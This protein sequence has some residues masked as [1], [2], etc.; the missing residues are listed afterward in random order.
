MNINKKDFTM[1]PTN[2]NI[3][4]SKFKRQHNNKLTYNTGHLVPIYV[5][6][7]LPGDTV[8]M[9]MSEIARMQ[10]PIFPVMDNGYIDTYFF[11]VPNRLVWEH[12]EE[13]MGEN[14]TGIWEQ[15]TE[16][17][18]P[19]IKFNTDMT[20]Y[21]NTYD[22]PFLKGA[23]KYYKTS[24]MCSSLADYMGIPI[25]DADKD[26]GP[27][28][29]YEVNALPFRAYYQIF[30]DWFRD[31][32]LMYPIEFDRGDAT[33]V[34]NIEGDLEECLPLWSPKYVAKFHDY[35]TS[36]LPQPQKSDDV[37]LPL[38][39]DAPIVGNGKGITFTDGT[40]TIYN[41]NSQVDLGGN[42]ML[43]GLTMTK[44]GDKVGDIGTANWDNTGAIDKQVLG[45]GE[46]TGLKVDL[47]GATAS[48]IN[49]L[50]QAFAV[51]KFYEQQA[52][53][54]SRYTEIIKS[55]F[56]VT[57]PD[58]RLQRA[59]YLGGARQAININQVVQQSA[60]DNG[61]TITQRGSSNADPIVYDMSK[62]STPQ[63]NVSAYSLTT[64]NNNIFTKS[65]TE[66]GILMGLQ[67]IRTEHSYQNGLNKLWSKRNK[68]D[69]Y[70][71]VFANIGE[72]AILNKEIYLNGAPEEGETDIDNEAFGY[73]EAWAEYRYHPNQ[74]S[75]EFRSN[76]QQT[77]D[78]WHW[79]DNYGAQVYLSS[80]WLEEN[81]AQVNRTIAVTDRKAD[82][83]MADIWFDATYTRPMPVYS[84]PGLIDHH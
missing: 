61:G 57:S 77:L 63:G 9:K 37:M 45:F 33:V 30:N 68:F 18:I 79:G 54:G 76:Y 74:I 6:E 44:M 82:Q 84:I 29:E 65:F 51:Q 72:Q 43:M 34:A 5:S 21:D 55:M 60:T 78:S 36:A 70:F 52:R 4:R 19:T 75:G 2:L 27:A 3:N 10:T 25:N 17:E 73:Q 26:K 22:I 47:S 46:E 69:F 64:M 15:E 35:F 28:G 24:P 8:Q 31:E 83:F 71:P 62:N 7:V 67:V 56:G 81:E 50:R 80:G 20:K 42:P 41:G 48:T 38:G 11:F 32:N 1:N 58:A 39:N 49:A 13:F 14:K 53:G 59:E 66:H 16:Y 23:E 40:H 12:W